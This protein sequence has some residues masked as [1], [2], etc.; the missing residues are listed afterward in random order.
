MITQE[1]LFGHGNISSSLTHIISYAWRESDWY[2]RIQKQAY[3]AFDVYKLASWL[4][5][6]YFKA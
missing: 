3:L 6:R 1:L 2:G 5:T 4:I